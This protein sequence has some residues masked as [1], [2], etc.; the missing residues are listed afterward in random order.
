MYA[1][2]CWIFCTLVTFCLI[3]AF[4]MYCTSRHKHLHMRS[5]NH[6]TYLWIVQI[7]N[8]LFFSPEIIFWRM[9][10]ERASKWLNGSKKRCSMA[11]WAEKS[12][13]RWFCRL[14]YRRQHQQLRNKSILFRQIQSNLLYRHNKFASILHATIHSH[15]N[16][17]SVKISIIC[18]HSQ[19]IVNYS[20]IKRE[21][22]RK[23]YKKKKKG[24]F[25][26]MQIRKLRN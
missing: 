6:F 23:I 17:Q 21:K 12:R 5:P 3:L 22:Q 25:F 2:E 18:C 26:Y 11:D 4:S 24:F 10:F 8:H 16:P 19:V 9:T 13:R 7:F 15:Q 1:C 14:Y 20:R